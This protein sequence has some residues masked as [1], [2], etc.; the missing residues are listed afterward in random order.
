MF[1]T[2]GKKAKANTKEVWVYNL[3]ASASQFGKRTA[4]TRDYFKAFEAAFGTDPLGSATSLAKRKDTG[5]EG[6]FRCFSRDWIAERGDNLDITW[7]N[8]DREEEGD[9]PEPAILAREAITELEAAL[10]ELQGILKEL[11]EDVD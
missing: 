2:R 5:E 4:L 7:L 1:F 3:R 8:G 9:L 6:E 10:T 11:G